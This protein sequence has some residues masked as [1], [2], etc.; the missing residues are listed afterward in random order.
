MPEFLRQLFSSGD[1]MPHGYCYMWNPG[2]VWL[3]VV[4]DS[5]ITAA[6]F[7]IPLVLLK[8]MRKRRDIPF[9]WVF[10]CFG[11][12]IVACGMTHAMEVWNLWHADYWLSGVIKAI[13][14]AASVGTAILLIRLIPKAEEL[15][16]LKTMQNAIDE[17]RQQAELLDLAHDAIFV[18]D[19]QGSIIYWNRGAQTLYGWTSE[20]ALG[21]TSHEL[22][23]TQFPK[24]LAEIESE[25]YEI[26]SWEGELIH[27]TRKGSMLT[28]ASR[29]SLRR[30]RDG[31]PVSILEINRDLT[32]RRFAERKF[33][34]LLET[35]PDAMVIVD[36]EGRIA[37]SNAQTERL[38]GYSRAE[39]AGQQIELLIP[40]RFRGKHE[41][42]RTGY[43]RTPRTRSMGAG[44]ELAGIRKDGSEFPVE[45]SL[46]PLE[47]EKGTLVTA[48]IRD[49]TERKQVERALKESEAR[50]QITL[51][52]VQVGTW[53]LDIVNNRSVRSLRHDQIFGYSAPQKEWTPDIFFR[54]VYPDDAEVARASFAEA[55]RT[56][57]LSMECRIVWPDCSIHWI[58]A[59]GCL[60][61]NEQNEPLRMMGV[62]EDITKRKEIE[63]AI[64][65][66]RNELARSNAELAAANEEMESF[67]YSVSHD[68]RAPLR[69]IHGFARILTEEYESRLDD[70][71]KH[72]LKRVVNGAEHMGQLVDDLLNLSRV[73]RRELQRQPTDLNEIVRATV[74][75]ISGLD[76]GAEIDWKI[77]PLP[78]MSCDAGLIRIV[79]TNLLGNAAKFTRRRERRVI[80]TGCS[81]GNGERVYYVRDN[82]VG[83]D[84]KYA[85]KLFGVFQRLHREEDFEGTGIGLAT[86]QRIVQKHGGRIWAESQPEK[87]ATFYFTLENP[88]KA[89]PEA[90]P[91]KEELYESKR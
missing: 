64:E 32:K 66:Q 19:L 65:I 12:F 81:N 58:A 9:N 90:A 39:L 2:L 85:E 40:E 52:S 43:F 76:A 60:Y 55:Y 28:V 18:R 80:E 34:S 86:V 87:G 88:E 36:E 42:H 35:A 57:G 59:Q 77:E 16:S 84:P 25:V 53:D 82:G 54:H 10:V 5:L 49:I 31:Q 15:P 33:E 45:I 23:Q 24:P 8:F 1:F 56:S 26:G 71:G 50:L 7:V 13:T 6:Y 89:V 68:L 73:G 74:A 44:L 51:D 27:Q 75:E 41:G 30:G 83:F 14:A 46:S 4:S 11:V 29:W 78:P 67:S 3:H 48:A 79:F 70:N 37:L 63:R 62:V 69:H 91:R 21:K 72:Y 17:L 22:L 61:R 20:E 38:F 47:T